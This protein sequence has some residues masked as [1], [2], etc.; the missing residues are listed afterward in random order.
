MGV[1]RVNGRGGVV[2]CVRVCMMLLWRS[3]AA[4]KEGQEYEGVVKMVAAHLVGHPWRGEEAC[5][6]CRGFLRGG[7]A[8]GG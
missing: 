7:E 1:G 2:W 3:C 5:E 8:W 4:M 6:E